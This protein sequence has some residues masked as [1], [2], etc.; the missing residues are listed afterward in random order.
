MVLKLKSNDYLRMAG[1]RGTQLEVLSGRVW[2]TEHGRE[3]DSFLAAG[4]RYRVSGDG[5]VL[6][7]TE[8]LVGAGGAEI[9][10]G[11]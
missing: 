7:G 4:G 1:A 9:S 2:V 10:I 11:S 8:T 3:A 6:I 5:L